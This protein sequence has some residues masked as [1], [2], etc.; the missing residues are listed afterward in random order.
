VGLASTLGLSGAAHAEK[1]AIEKIEKIEESAHSSHP[2][3]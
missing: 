2:V 1:R 3:S